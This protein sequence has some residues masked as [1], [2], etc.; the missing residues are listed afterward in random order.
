MGEE[1]NGVLLYNV[2][3]LYI[4]RVASIHT[5][6]GFLL[7]P[8]MANVALHLWL[9]S[10]YMEVILFQVSWGGLVCRLART[11]LELL[12]GGIVLG[13]EARGVQ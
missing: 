6:A 11:E 5:L 8:N 4:H 3:V 13:G 9:G 7:V 1:Y 2:Q 12:C 10:W